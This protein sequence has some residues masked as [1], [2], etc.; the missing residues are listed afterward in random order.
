MPSPQDR[1]EENR[2]EPDAGPSPE[3]ESPVPRGE[4]AVSSDVKFTVLS[5]QASGYYHTVTTIA[6]A[7]LGGSLLFIEKI[8]PHP[9]PWTLGLLGA[10]WVC[11]LA[12]IGFIT[13]VRRTNMLSMRLAMR[14]EQELAQDIDKVARR[15]CMIGQY[16]LILGMLLVSLYGLANVALATREPQEDNMAKT[17][18]ITK[19]DKRGIPFSISGGDTGGRP[20]SPPKPRP[21][22]PRG[23][24][25]GKKK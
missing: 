22:Q 24:E 13:D 16:A 12:A 5:E 20:A 17:Q 15:S 21:A 1:L 18:I 19:V 9:V 25:K 3:P 8:A 7:F 6:T 10:G 23:G 4:E 14:S 2:A 11:L